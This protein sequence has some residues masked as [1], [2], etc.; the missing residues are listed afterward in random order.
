MKARWHGFLANG[1]A[2]VVAFFRGRQPAGISDLKPAAHHY[3]W[4]AVYPEDLDWRAEISVKPL[5][6]VLDDAVERF[7]DNPCVDFFGKKYSYRDIGRLVDCAAKGLQELGVGK[8]VH[9]GLFLPNC[10]YFVIFYYAVLKVGGTVVNINPLVST[11]ISAQ[12]AGR[13]VIL[14]KLPAGMPHHGQADAATATRSAFLAW[15]EAERD[16]R[17]VVIGFATRRRDFASRCRAG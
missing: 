10:P 11:P 1:L 9:V 16:D 5:F 12:R 7:P 4:E 17:L 13:L 15:R 2:L 8:G 6:A 14:A 3:P